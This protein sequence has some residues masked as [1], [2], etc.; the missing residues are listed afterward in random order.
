MAEAGSRR[1][2]RVIVVDAENPL[3]E[4]HGEFFWRE[5]HEVLLVAA[6]D[7]AFRVGH[8]QGYRQGYAVGWEDSA[9]QQPPARVVLRRR[10]SLL[11]WVRLVIVL[12]LLVAFGPLLVSVALQQ[13]LTLR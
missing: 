13:L 11:G 5:D 7:E 1:P 4:I 3:E 8:D 9:R 2:K 12:M 6:R 10:R